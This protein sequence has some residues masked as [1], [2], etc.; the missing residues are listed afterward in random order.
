MKSKLKKVL[1]LSSTS[2]AAMGSI[3]GGSAL[4][5]KNENINTDENSAIA[6]NNTFTNSKR[7][8]FDP[9]KPLE[10]QGERYPNLYSAIDD[11]VNTPGNV[12]EE[13]YLGDIDNAITNENNM[14]GGF[15][16]VDLNKLN[17][18]D[19]AKLDKAYKTASDKY[20]PS[21]LEA[22]KSYLRNPVVAWTD[23]NGM[24]FD[25]ETEAKEFISNNVDTTPIAYYEIEDHS[26]LNAINKPSIVNI[27]PL[28]KDD[29]K[30][31]KRLAID[32]M[33]INN[34]GFKL[35]RFA[36]DKDGV[37]VPAD[38]IGKPVSE[39]EALTS[40][41]IKG[42]TET[43]KK[44]LWLNVEMN[45][46]LD[47]S[48]IVYK[49]V[50]ISPGPGN[51][52]SS[53][54]EQREMQGR[55]NASF[56]DNSS[57]TYTNYDKIVEDSKIL[58]NKDTITDVM[59]LSN[60]SNRHN[61][62]K[63][64]SLKKGKSVYG[65]TKAEFRFAENANLLEGQHQ[66][67]YLKTNEAISFGGRG[68]YRNVL[69]SLNFNQNKFAEWFA[70]P[71]NQDIWNPKIT[72]TVDKVNAVVKNTLSDH[73]VAE[74]S[75]NKLVEL[76]EA[77]IKELMSSK[78]VENGE[79][80]MNKILDGSNISAVLDTLDRII[81]DKLNAKIIQATGEKKDLIQMVNDMFSKVYWSD[82]KIESSNV[83]YA[84]TYNGHELFKINNQLFSDLYVGSNDFRAQ[85]LET[86]KAFIKNLLVKNYS[87]NMDKITGSMDNISNSFSKES[88]PTAQKVNT[89]LSQ[90]AIDSYNDKPVNLFGFGTANISTNFDPKYK[91][92]FIDSEFKKYGANESTFKSSLVAKRDDDKANLNS[93]WGT[94]EAIHQYNKNL[95]NLLT[96]TN[97]PSNVQKKQ[98]E[99]NAV[100]NLNDIVSLF[101]K[102]GKPSKI[103]YSEYFNNSFKFN[104]SLS[105]GGAVKLVTSEE[106]KQIF[107]ESN[108]LNKPTKVVVVKDLEG[109]VVNTTSINGDTVTG[110]G[111]ATESMQAYENALNSVNVKEDLSKIFYTDDSGKKILLENKVTK[112]NVLKLTL[113]VTETRWGFMKYSDL[114][115]YLSQFIKMNS[116]GNGNKPID[117]AVVPFT[118]QT[119]DFNT[120]RR[121]LSG[122][123][124]LSELNNLS[125][126]EKFNRFGAAFGLKTLNSWLMYI[127]NL[128]FTA[129][130]NKND[131]KF[132]RMT[133]DLKKGYRFADGKT[134]L[135]VVV[136]YKSIG[137]L[138]G[139]SPT[140]KKIRAATISGVSSAILAIV[141]L[142]VI[143][144]TSML[145]NKRNKETDVE[146]KLMRLV[147][148]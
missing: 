78:I 46:T 68:S 53:V 121:E 6:V 93:N 63:N 109:N 96:K 14:M 127:D 87:V 29:V 120:I 118:L 144:I 129:L 43:V 99:K 9:D 119:I 122:A 86:I 37:Y 94:F 27:N 111:Y 76:L 52:V 3:V 110:D 5:V 81:F 74:S 97:Q 145:V 66:P 128:H 48:S 19:S 39:I 108:K 143:V 148:K 88:T 89:Q 138:G 67:D 12:T 115:S 50:T 84:V 131:T 104:E 124:S 56:E 11:Y 123:K 16:V 134:S 30:A 101:E 126:E 135:K 38:F 4:A 41:L 1:I 59:D 36:T 62:V 70:K 7:G 139:I 112:L 106:Q 107:I 13:L 22:K 25:T 35:E 147:K 42:I 142:E 132:A 65:H 79:V 51:N 55:Y 75:I 92:M 60:A 137:D 24:I 32:N 77:P 33:F 40:N 47:N 31:L 98:L 57:M 90:N 102:D 10:F 45:P 69:F 72:S 85:P 15:S 133:I 21:L 103:K 140:D 146:K 80:S 18:Y 117:P 71:G 91:S 34:S 20:T 116:T 113:N 61:R 2:M 44:N 130:K 54:T 49:D 125:D 58:L 73:K 141:I 26:K 28:N 17:V 23:N 105:D 8:N 114:Y 136:D 95:N 100:T 64:A 82:E 83:I